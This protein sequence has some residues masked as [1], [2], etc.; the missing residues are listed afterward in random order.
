MSDNVRVILAV[1]AAG[2]AGTI[3]NSLAVVFAF[4]EIDL[5]ALLA[6]YGRFIVAIA[7][8]ALLPVIY[9]Q[10][11]GSSA[12]VTALAALTIIPSV[13]A[14]LVFGVGAS[15]IMV[16]LLNLVFAVVAWAVYLWVMGRNQSGS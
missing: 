7:V 11:S 12:V 5:V 2:I 10:M 9:S 1:I 16:L 13:L 4:P 15:W 14:K 3:V 8:A 6:K